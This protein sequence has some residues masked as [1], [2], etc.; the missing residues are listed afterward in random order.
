MP[1]LTQEQAARWEEEL[2]RLEGDPATTVRQMRLFMQ[3]PMECGHA[4]GDLLTCDV[5]PNGCAAC[6]TQE[7]WTG[8]LE[9]VVDGELVPDARAT[10]G[11]RVL[12]NLTVVSARI[13]GDGE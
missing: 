7:R 2:R 13:V 9:V 3:H 11:L 10:S 4:V 6:G 1:R 5:P 12:R 8:R